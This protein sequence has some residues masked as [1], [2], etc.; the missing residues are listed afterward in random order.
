M[1]IHAIAAGVKRYNVGGVGAESLATM[2]SGMHKIRDQ[3]AK[4]G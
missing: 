4:L 3:L 2:L 1:A